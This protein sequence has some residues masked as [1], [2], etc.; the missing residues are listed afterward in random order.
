MQPRNQGWDGRNVCPR[1]QSSRLNCEGLRHLQ[2]LHTIKGYETLLHTRQVPSTNKTTIAGGKI[3]QSN[4]IKSTTKKRQSL[5]GQA[6]YTP[7]ST[8]LKNVVKFN[9]LAVYW[10]A[11]LS[12]DFLFSRQMDTRFL[13]THLICT[14]R[15]T[16]IAK[17]IPVPWTGINEVFYAY[18]NPYNASNNSA[19]IC[20]TNKGNFHFSPMGI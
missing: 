10:K 3:H 14:S 19:I 18:S 15:V 8:P 6:H 2:P 12:C 5:A 7:N 4:H 17:R 11:L 9:R 13:A 16:A 20:H 1:R